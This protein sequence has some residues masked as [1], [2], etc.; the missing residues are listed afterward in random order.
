MKTKTYRVSY[1]M[2]NG[3]RCGCCRSTS[4]YTEDFYDEKSLIQWLTNFE[5]N[6][7]N[8]DFDIS[9]CW[10][11]DIC[12]IEDVTDKFKYD[13]EIKRKLEKERDERKIKEQEEIEAEEKERRLKEYERLKKEFGDGTNK[14]LEK[15]KE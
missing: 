8:N 14:K 4:D 13:P 6:R 3:Y 15:L 2:G 7:C 9:D 12:I 1:G 5:M 10:L 11:N